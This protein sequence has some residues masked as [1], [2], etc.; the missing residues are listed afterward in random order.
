MNC[1][2]II[3]NQSLMI[4]CIWIGGSINEWRKNLVNYKERNLKRERVGSYIKGKVSKKER[5]GINTK[6]ITD[7]FTIKSD[8]DNKT[9]TH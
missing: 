9:I 3:A 6:E 2:K 7:R 4:S 1:D 8:Q 5:K